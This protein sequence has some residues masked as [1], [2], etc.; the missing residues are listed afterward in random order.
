MT[1]ARAWRA[2]EDLKLGSGHSFSTIRPSGDRDRDRQ[3]LGRPYAA[4]IALEVPGEL[5]WSASTSSTEPRN[6]P[7][8]DG[9]LVPQRVQ[10]S[11][12]EG[13]SSLEMNT[14]AWVRRSMPSLA[15]NRD[16]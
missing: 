1:R 8:P 15:N 6:G 12:R 7:P 16:T 4:R 5:P 10:S 2:G 3:G 9:E 14:A 11:K 13:R